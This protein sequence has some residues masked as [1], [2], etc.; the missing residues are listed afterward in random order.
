MCRA[1][2]AADKL[3]PNRVIDELVTIA[4]IHSLEHLKSANGLKKI[5][6][7]AS[8]IIATSSSSSSSDAVERKS[9]RNCKS[10]EGNCKVGE[11]GAPKRSHD[12]FLSNPE[13]RINIQRGSDP[14]NNGSEVVPNIEKKV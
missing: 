10:L 11:S 4:K 1:A 2:A 13:K 6:N 3:T 8:E 7:A 14:E 5:R 12:D 9:V